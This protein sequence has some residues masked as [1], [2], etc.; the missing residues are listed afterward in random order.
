MRV[1][2]SAGKGKVRVLAP[3]VCTRCIEKMLLCKLGTGKSMLCQACK[4]V[5][6]QCERPGEEEV[7][8]K[9]VC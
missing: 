9:V 3:E 2:Q 7:E 8:P 1:E 5:K 6:V 4:V